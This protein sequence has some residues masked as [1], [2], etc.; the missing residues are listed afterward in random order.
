MR[1]GRIFLDQRIDILNVDDKSTSNHY[2]LRVS[3]II[4]D[5]SLH[6]VVL[7]FLY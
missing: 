7:L 2:V 3:F 4:Y 5:I 6:I 1:I